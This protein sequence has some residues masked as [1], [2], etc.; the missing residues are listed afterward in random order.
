MSGY[1]CAS[2]DRYIGELK[3]DQNKFVNW[4]KI[5]EKE[6][7]EAQFLKVGNGYSRLLQLINF[8]SN[9]KMTLNPFANNIRRNSS[10]SHKNKSTSSNDLYESSSRKDR[11]I[12]SVRNK[13][14]YSK[15]KNKTID[16]NKSINEENTNDKKLPIIKPSMSIDNYEK[17]N[18]KKNDVDPRIKSQ[19]NNSHL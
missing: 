2:C 11:V 3:S 14:D 5:K 1:S 8:D 12:Y 19:R 15:E 16:I 7:K 9:G 6:I 18:E 10:V 13:R 17:L 4:K